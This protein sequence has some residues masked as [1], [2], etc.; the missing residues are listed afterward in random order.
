M[1][2]DVAYNDFKQRSWGWM[3][4]A[5]ASWQPLKGLSMTGMGGYFSTDD[6]AS[7]IYVYERGPLYAFS[8]PAFYGRGIRYALLL[9]ADV[10]V[11]NQYVKTCWHSADR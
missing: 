6:Y 1:Q 10:S 11:W 5:T 9:R 7:R 2:G 4:S 3:A 8:F